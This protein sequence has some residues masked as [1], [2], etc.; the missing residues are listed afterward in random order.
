MTSFHSYEIL[1]Q[2]WM[3]PSFWM[4][5]KEKQSF[6]CCYCEDKSISWSNF[7]SCCICSCF[8]L[9]PCWQAWLYIINNTIRKQVNKLFTWRDLSE[10]HPCGKLKG[11]WICLLL[12]QLSHSTFD[13]YSHVFLELPTNWSVVI[14]K[15]NNNNNNAISTCC[16]WL[17]SMWFMCRVLKWALEELRAFQEVTNFNTAFQTALNELS[18]LVILLPSQSLLVARITTTRT[19]TKIA[20]KRVIAN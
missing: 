3:R 1:W 19:R 11:G 20:S 9:C 15:Q 6:C 7:C 2:Y 12:S 8:C 18:K 4:A 17:Q 5:L 13:N 16:C 10:S 14:K